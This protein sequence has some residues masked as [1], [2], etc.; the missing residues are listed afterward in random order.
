LA[1]PVCDR[2]THYSYVDDD[3]AGIHQSYVTVSTYILKFWS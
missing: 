3:P 2:I 1:N